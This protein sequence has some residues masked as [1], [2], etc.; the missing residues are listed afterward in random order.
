MTPTLIG[1]AAL[2]AV[3]QLFMLNRMGKAPQAADP[4]PKVW[5][6]MRE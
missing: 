3:A 1:L 2:A 6:E 4:N 5:G